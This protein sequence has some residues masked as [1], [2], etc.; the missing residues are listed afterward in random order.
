MSD[1]LPPTQTTAVSDGIIERTNAQIEIYQRV[2]THDIPRI[3]ELAAAA[4]VPAIV[5]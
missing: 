5:P 4:G 3:N 1:H 2:R